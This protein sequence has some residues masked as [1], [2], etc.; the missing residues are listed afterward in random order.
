MYKNTLSRRD[1]LKLA[2]VRLGATALTC[3]GL[4]C[5]ATYSPEIET[6]ELIYGKENPMNK[7][8]LVTYATRAGSTVEVAA[9]IGE[10]LS[11]RGFVVDVKP[12]KDQPRL[13]GCQAVVMG[14]A[15]RMGQWLPEAVEFVKANQ[16]ALNRMPVALFTVHMLNIGDDEQ[17]RT[18]RLAY[19]NT[20][21]PLLQKADE[22]YFAGKMDFSR[23]SFLDRL[24][25]GMVKA[26]EGDRRDWDNI[27]NWAQTIL[28]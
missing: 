7:R 10:T 20:V 8:I 22:V 21:R 23:L 13:D 2:G 5:A 1:F 19:L 25:S 27:R 11:A 16:Q 28:A 12:V 15:I 3:S 26:Q 9:A 4:G 17:S 14:S 6:P 24:I 18:N